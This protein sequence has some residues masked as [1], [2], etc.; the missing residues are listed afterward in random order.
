MPTDVKSFPLLGGENLTGSM[1]L[2]EPGELLFSLNYEPDTEGYPRRVDGFERFDGRQRPSEASYYVL[3][4]TEGCEAIPV[5]ST[6]TGATSGATGKVIAVLVEVGDLSGGEGC[7]PGTDGGR[8]VL[9]HVTGTFVDAEVLQVAGSDIATASGTTQM[10]WSDTDDHY[11]EWLGLAAESYRG[12]IQ[13][14]PGVGPIL[15]V[16]AFNDEIYAFRDAAGLTET[17]MFKASAS[18]WVQQDLGAALAFSSGTAAF[19]AGETVTGGTSGATGVVVSV[20]VDSGDWGTNDAAGTLYLKTLSGTFQ[21][22]TITGA[23]GSATAAGAQVANTLPPGGKYRFDNY[24][25]YGGADGLRMYGV[26][27]VGYAFEWDGS[28][29]SWIKTGATVDTPTHVIGHS[30]HL[31]LGYPGGGFQN[32]SI[33]NP[34]EWD[35]VTGAAL[36]GLGDELTGWVVT[37]GSTLTV[38]G[39]NRTSILYGTSEADWELRPHSTKA[40]AAV[41]TIQDINGPKYLGESGFT[42]ME[43]TAAYGDF[44]AGTFSEKMQPLIDA[45][46][47]TVINSV[48]VEQ[49]KQYRAFFEGGAGLTITF[50]A[51]GPSFMRFQLGKSVRCIVN[52]RNASGGEEMYFGSDDGYVYQLDKGTSFDGDPV[53]AFLRLNFHHYG[54]PRHKKR[55]HMVVVEARVPGNITAYLLPD[56]SFGTPDLPASIDQHLAAV[57]QLL[58]VDTVGG[59]WGTA[60]W[61][62]FIWSGAALSEIVAYLDGSATNLGLYLRTVGTYDPPHTFETVHV[63]YARRGLQRGNYE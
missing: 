17:R 37:Q 26:N 9:T 23:T 39:E 62:Q 13:K 5:G 59:Y 11:Y 63:H 52:T 27:G 47:Q 31:F 30:N 34:L 38:F 60:I 36:F 10:N 35:A 22:E 58:S 14:V 55:F 61:E 20:K 49:K 18:G 46:R 32:S 7:Y 45:F 12:D 21:A 56:F 51:R 57:D 28:G 42:S 1:A 41:D 33:G 2:M 53:E 4:F 19:A 54:S 3:T 8:L 25:F 44:L 16:W 40:G 15:G 29:L 43:A 48:K 50:T 6:V 24:N